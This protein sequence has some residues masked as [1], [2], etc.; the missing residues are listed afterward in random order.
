MLARLP[1]WRMLAP[2]VPACDDVVKLGK[3]CQH[4]SVDAPFAAEI[5]V[6]LR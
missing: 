5:A 1:S 3:S 6:T 2:I 4:S